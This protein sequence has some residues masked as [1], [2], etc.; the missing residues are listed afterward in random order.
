MS[1]RPRARANI[2]P[3]TPGQMNK[4]ERSYANR[5]ELLQRD[6]KVHQY[7]YESH[8]VKLADRTWYSPDFMVQFPDGTV[9][10]HEVKGFWE[11]DA[12][13]KVKVAA[14]LFPFTVRCFTKRKGE[15]VEE[16]FGEEG[17][18]SS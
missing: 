3:R 8:K 5:L 6:G 7:W 4:T 16:T 9:E 18:C 10:F 15:W 17:P 1:F 13:V 2:R 14:R 11:D 12:R